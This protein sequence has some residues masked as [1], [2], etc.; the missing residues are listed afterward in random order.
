MLR[1]MRATGLLYRRSMIPEDPEMVMDV[2]IN[3]IQAST[4]TG[5]ECIERKEVYDCEKPH[6]NGALLQKVALR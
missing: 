1:G 3:N 5:K 2:N 6:Y 4:K